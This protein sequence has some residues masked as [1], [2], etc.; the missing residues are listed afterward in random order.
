[1]VSLLRA[2]CAL[3]AKRG[4]MSF[5]A[6]IHSRGGLT[7]PV[8]VGEIKAR[9]QA[10]AY[11]TALKNSAVRR[12]VGKQETGDLILKIHNAPNPEAARALAFGEDRTC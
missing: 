4:S 9:T 1:M 8:L 12:F 2:A 7:C 6:Y 5:Y 3:L 10:D 11:A